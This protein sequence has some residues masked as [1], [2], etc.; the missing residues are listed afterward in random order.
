SITILTL[1]GNLLVIIT[2]AHFK[3]LHTPSNYLVFSLAVTDFLLGAVIIPPCMVCSLDWLVLG[4]YGGTLKILCTT[5]RRATSAQ[6]RVC[7]NVNLK[8]RTILNKTEF[9]A[10]RTQ[11]II[12]SADLFYW[13]HF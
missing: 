10:T 4:W 1:F 6:S 5:R 3:Q 9:K 8:R 13:T 7:A 12:I 11:G 2:V